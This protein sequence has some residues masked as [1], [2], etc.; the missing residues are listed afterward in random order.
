MTLRNRLAILSR[1]HRA[2]A[3][4]YN[5]GH[6]SP[7][8]TKEEQEDRKRAQTTSVLASIRPTEQAAAEENAAD[9][10]DHTYPPTAHDSLNQGWAATAT[11][12]GATTR[13]SPPQFGRGRILTMPCQG[14]VGGQQ[15]GR[16]S[17]NRD[18]RRS[19]LGSCTRRM[20]KRK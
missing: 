19:R 17:C 10:A 2:P 14:E 5:R 18:K 3:D 4:T 15:V 13:R 6:H 9:S 11:T 1:S 16:E 8:W 7:R 20:P 12:P